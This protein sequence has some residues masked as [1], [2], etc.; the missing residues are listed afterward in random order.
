MANDAPLTTETSTADSEPAL[1][2]PSTEFHEIVIVGGGAAGLELATQLGH[3]A[4]KGK[5]ARVTLMECRRTHLWK[6]L[7]HA[8]AAGSMN[9]GEH[10]L[11]YLAQ[12][13]WHGF[14]WRFGEMTGLDRAKKHVMIG[15]TYDE[16]GKRIT[17]AR[18]FRYDTLVIAIGSI[19]NDFGTPGVAKYAVPLETTDQAVRFNRRLVNAC[20]RA[21]GQLG[22]VRPGQLHVAII[23]AGAT[24]TEMAAELFRTIREMVSFG[25]TRIDPK[26]DINIILIE[27]ADRILPA[28]PERVSNATRKLLE[29]LGVQVRTGAR[30]S[31][32]TAD[33]VRLASGET[34]PSELVVWAAGVRGPDVL[35]TLDG[36]E[37]NRINQLVVTP[38]LQTTRDPD[39]FAMGDCASCPRPGHPNPVPPRAQA[40]HQQAAH[41]LKQIRRRLAGQPLQ[42]FVYKD[43]GSLVSLG[44][45]ST[46]G[47][48]MG[49]IVGKGLFVEGYFAR[50]MYR[51]L[52]TMHQMAVHG[53]RKT[54]LGTLG[55]SLTRKSGPDVKLH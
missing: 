40:A 29:E 33:G 24:G 52:Y 23:G 4:R 25:M 2:D 41:M 54:L 30:V 10:E 9:P 47:H 14:R 26:R 22:P 7:L 48:L 5:Q 39:V 3:V 1:F 27:A 34:I 53:G 20:I 28:L 38:T 6:P 18:K 15:A 17:P 16:D 51:S 12:A 11:N 21:N 44:E 46:V 8:V 50:L 45:Y 36:L 13:H 42:P 43:F 37:T 19:T 49:F 31:E 55:R 32:V 35:K